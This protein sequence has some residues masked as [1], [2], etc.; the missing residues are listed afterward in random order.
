MSNRSESQHEQPTTRSRRWLWIIAAGFVLLMSVCAAV[1]MLLWLQSTADPISAGLE[2]AA[3]TALQNPGSAAIDLGLY[4]YP[5]WYP[6]NGSDYAVEN[7]MVIFPQPPGGNP[8]QQ[9]FKDILPDKTMPALVYAPGG[10][11]LPQD[12]NP[13]IPDN[14][15]WAYMSE[16]FLYHCAPISK[17]PGW[18]DCMLLVG[19]NI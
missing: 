5:R 16:W 18:W 19:G 10:Q 17:H 15:S 14:R 13:P 12:A 7:G 9:P 2:Q 11:T 3:N 6:A 4:S 8:F 1:A